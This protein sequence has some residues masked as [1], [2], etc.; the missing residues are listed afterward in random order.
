MPGT[1]KH[2]PRCL[3]YP[4]SLIDCGCPDAPGRRDRFGGGLELEPEIFERLFDA[5]SEAQYVLSIASGRYVRVNASFETLTGYS[6]EDLEGGRIGPEHMV[7]PEDR[8]LISSKRL[9]RHKL[10]SDSYELRIRSSDGTVKHLEICVKLLDMLGGDMV[11]GHVRDIT[12][13]KRLELRLKEEVELQKKRTLDAAKASVRIFQLTEK[14]RNVPRLTTALLD[15]PDEPA[16][17]NRAAEI[18]VDRSGLNYARATILLAKDGALFPAKTLPAGYK[19]RESYPI[20]SHSR[21]SKVARES[22]NWT[23]RKGEFIVPLRARGEVI[24]VLEVC[25]D[26]EEKILF[27]DSET[28]RLGQEDIVRTLSNSIGMMIENLRLLER[29]RQ[30]SIMDQVTQTYNRRHFDRKLGEE[31]KRS[32][33]YGRKVGLLMLD[34]DYFKD[35]NDTWGHQTGDKVLASLGEIFKSTSRDLD[36][37]CRYGGDEFAILLPET[38]GDAATVRAERLRVMV[39][40]KRFENPSNPDI[41]LHLTISIGVA[42]MS[43]EHFTPGDLVRAAD[44]ACYKS[45]KQGRN[46]V[47]FLESGGATGVAPVRFGDFGSEDAE[48]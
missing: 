13:R 42:A 9:S 28:V 24:G 18:L 37:V 22:T 2:G 29:I 3:P 16:L 14:I 20:S 11:L 4:V 47:N 39:E 38:D 36:V 23:G 33:R 15:A 17:L 8:P 30:Q 5:S 40:E 45:K 34:V 32:R 31:V 48:G 10:L 43:D 12:V 1:G 7:V 6:R 26:Q 35:V 25:F 21:Y 19:M 27:D 41:P 44:E 46:R